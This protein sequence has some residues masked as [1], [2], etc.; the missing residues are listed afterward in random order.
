MRGEIEDALHLL[1]Q[2]LDEAE[3]RGMTAFV[4]WPESF[5]GELDLVLGDLD[6][7]EA[8]F[9]HAFALGCQVGDPCWESIAL[10]GL[11]LVAEA[12]GDVARALEL[13]VDAPK[14]CRRLP[15]TY[16]WI[17]AYGL[18]ALCSVAV[19]HGA[20]A[21]PS[22]STSLRRS[23][24]GAASA[25]C[26]CGRPSTA[27]GW[28][29][30][31][32]SPP[33]SRSRRRSTVLSSSGL[34]EPLVGGQAGGGERVGDGLVEVERASRLARVG[35]DVRRRHVRAGRPAAA[36]LAEALGR[37]EEPAGALGI[38]GRGESGEP[39][40]RVR[41]AAPVA[42][43]RERAECL[44]EADAGLVASSPGGG[45]L[46]EDLQ[47]ARVVERALVEPCE[48]GFAPG[49]RPRARSPSRSASSAKQSAARAPAPAAA[50]S[51]A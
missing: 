20:E 16:L 12:R 49:S 31:A 11:G 50:L 22:G 37:A 24:H 45:D 35:G 28:G 32:R 5:R 42:E 30:R 41:D 7:A 21:T 15:D 14:L 2:A 29:S 39:V 36:G 3:V 9:E 27:R 48:R 46:A 6:A 38:S 18:D 17:E 47:A 43:R 1:D 13:L 23:P 4:P 33:P 10:R 8:R 44:L 40:E 34:L 25:S 51:S 26:S 19:D